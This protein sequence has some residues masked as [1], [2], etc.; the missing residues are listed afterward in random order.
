VA[1]PRRVKP[2]ADRT[3]I[4]KR[5]ERQ[6]QFLFEA[7]ETREDGGEI[8]TFSF[9]SEEPVERYWGR[10]VLS[11]EDGAADFSRIEAGVAPYLFNHDRDVVLGRV[12]RG[13]ME[14]RRGRCEIEWSPVTKV[15][16]STPWQRRMEIE[17]GMVPGVSFAYEIQDVREAGDVFMVTK[18]PI[19][20]ISS[21]TIPADQTVGIG[22]AHDSEPEEV[23]NLAEESEEPI[24]SPVPALPVRTVETPVVDVEK[25]RSEAILAERDRA[26]SIRAMAARFNLSD[27]GEELVRGGKSVS[28]AHAAVLERIGARNPEPVAET[29]GDIGMSDSEVRQFRFLRALNYLA[30]PNDRQAREAAAYEIEVSDAA[31]KRYGKST[32]GITVPN[33]VLRRDLTVGVPSAGGN[34]VSTDLLVGSFIELFRNRLALAQA[35][36]TV[37]NGLTDN[38]AIPRQTSSATAYWIGE[39][40]APTE[41]Q[42]AVDQ[43]NMSP[44]GLAAFTDY[45]RRLLLQASIDVEN[46]IRNDFVRIMALEADRAGIYGTGGANQPLGL[47]ATTG[48]GTQVITGVGTF[49][50]YIG[51]ETDLG[52]A[53]ADA[54]ALRYI[55][56]ATTRGGL[57]SVSKVGTEAQ[58]VYERMNGQDEINGYPV[59]VSNQLLN[60]DCLFGDFSQMVMGFWSG[61]DLMVDPYAG[62]TAGNVRIIAMQDMDIAVRQPTAFCFGT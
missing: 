17:S 7:T 4:G 46:M 30:N 40:G 49:A 8:A 1:T 15:E 19:L 36:V 53:N 35:G 25:A 50:E 21:V 43:V 23:P 26:E 22:R 41:S 14:E 59:I 28:E 60:N 56:N 11:H 48:I 37:L 39:G 6:G 31:Q 54:G 61:L 2:K 5:F 3:F 13:W 34:L 27:L 47:T 52:V 20:E 55:V 29:N 32:N 57:K 24:G 33:D 42:Q 62:A 16:G 18:W 12:L 45:S 9:S 51:M 44:K 10:E 38:I 58:F